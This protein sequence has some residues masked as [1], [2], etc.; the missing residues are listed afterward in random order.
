MTD[1]K[2]DIGQRKSLRQDF[3]KR[4]E[5]RRR[6]KK[7]ARR[8]RILAAFITAIIVIIFLLGTTIYSF[9][10][11]L[12]SDEIMAGNAPKKNQSLNILLLGMDIGDLDNDNSPKRTDTI[13]VLNYNPNTKNVQIVSVP[14]DTLI[15]VED[16][17]DGNGNYMPYWKI[18]SAY[19]LGG[20]E[21]VVMHVEDLLDININYIVEINYNAFR[22]IIDAIGGV[23]MYIENDMYYDD[24]MQDLHINFKGGETVLLDGKQAEEFFRWRQNN[25]GTGLVDG[26]IGRIRNQQKFISKVI[27]KC[28]SPSIITKIP[29]ILD[30]LKENIVTNMPGSK[31]LS[32]GLDIVTNSGMAMYTLQ[33]YTENIYGQ[34]FLVVEKE[35]NQDILKALNSGSTTDN[36]VEREI[37][38]I[39][40][41]N[42]TR[43]T[44]LAANLKTELENIGYSNISIGN[45]EKSEKSSILCND[46]ALGKLISTDTGINNIEKI[47]S[48]EYSGYDAVIIIGEDYLIFGE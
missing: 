9:I 39:N 36:P 27:E 38:N 17:Y 5:A 31:I 42:G 21:E 11:G 25:D 29:N 6:A 26:D 10:S 48:S 23:E 14:R 13:I 32:Y 45:A 20:E 41:L 8:R 22:N 12:K 46:K 35:E 37:Y 24:D 3:E 2:D 16:A 19:A 30:A 18:N 40:V 33:G 15:E 43:V 7:I 44:G 4:K 28:T 47:K 1:R 34:S